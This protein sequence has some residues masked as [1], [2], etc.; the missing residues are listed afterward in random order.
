MRLTIR[1]VITMILLM[2]ILHDLMYIYIYVCV[3][4]HTYYT[5]RN[6]ILLVYEVY[7]RS[8]TIFL[9]STLVMVILIIARPTARASVETCAAKGPN[10][11]QLPGPLGLQ[12]KASSFWSG[13][14][15]HSE[16]S[17]AWTSTGPKPSYSL[18]LLGSRDLNEQGL[19]TLRPHPRSTLDAKGNDYPAT[20]TKKHPM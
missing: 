17:E 15:P 19:G 13:A 16:A 18:G 4:I 9:L 14:P 6:P 1:N 12:P 5:I 10:L 11:Q 7:I 8:R 20:P 3:Y 2:S